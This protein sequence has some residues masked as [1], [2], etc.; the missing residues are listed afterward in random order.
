MLLSSCFNVL[1]N[2]GVY[3]PAW[4]EDG[5]KPVDI[6]TKKPL[7]CMNK[8]VVHHLCMAMQLE[9]RWLTHGMNSKLH[10]GQN[11]KTPSSL[12]SNPSNGSLFGLHNEEL[13]SF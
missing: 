9:A 7:V 11:T 12:L 3:E 4:D 8:R 6:C 2:D 10:C 5:F 13:C 1:R